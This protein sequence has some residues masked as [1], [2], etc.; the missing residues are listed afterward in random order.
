M[1]GLRQFLD[2]SSHILGVRSALALKHREVFSCFTFASM[3]IIDSSSHGF[4]TASS[5]PNGNSLM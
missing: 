2:S 3:V 4:L 1:L 5:A